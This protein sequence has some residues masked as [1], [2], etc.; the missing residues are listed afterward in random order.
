M[1]AKAISEAKGKEILNN[2]LKDVASKNRFAIVTE[3]V[4]WEKLIL[5]QP[6]LQSDVRHLFS[7]CRILVKNQAPRVLKPLK[8]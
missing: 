5:E 6:W 1:S 3:D 7:A 2:N 8:T 4:S